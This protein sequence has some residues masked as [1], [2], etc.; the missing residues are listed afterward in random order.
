MVNDN[1]NDFRLS[2]EYFP[3]KLLFNLS[4]LSTNLENDFLPTS[5]RATA[6]KFSTVDCCVSFYHHTKN[7][8]AYGFAD[9]EFGDFLELFINGETDF[10]D[11]F[12]TTLSWWERRND[13]NVL[14]ITY[15]ELKQDTE[16]N[17][18][19]IAS[20]IGSEY[21]EKLEK[22]EKMLQDV[23]RHSSFD[24]MKEHLNKLIGEIRRTPKEMIQDNPD[25]PA[26]FKAVLLSHQRQKERN[27]SRST[28]IRKGQFSFWM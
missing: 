5:N 7:A 1:T 6:L 14:F 8:S 26:G 27:D 22:D 18:L 16:K 10:G 11:Y 2:E 24:F 15:E 12:D 17:V 28:F 3:Y 21:K 4:V 23:I 13:P 25:I 9:G 20:F 19:K